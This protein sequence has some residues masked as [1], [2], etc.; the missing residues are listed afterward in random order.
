MNLFSIFALFSQIND[1][2]TFEEPIKDDVWEQA[3]DEEIDYIEKN[4]TCELVDL[5]KGKDVVIGK[6]VYKTKQYVEGNV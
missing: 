4:Q 6:W 5:S 2:L 3:M 1:P